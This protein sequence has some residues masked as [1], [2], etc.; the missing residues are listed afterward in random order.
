MCREGQLKQPQA[1]IIADKNFPG[2]SEAFKIKERRGKE[3]AWLRVPFKNV[4]DDTVQDAWERVEGLKGSEDAFNR[5][6]RTLREKE[7]ALKVRQKREAGERQ[8]R[9]TQA[10]A[11]K[12]RARIRREGEGGSINNPLEL[13]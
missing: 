3:E 10:A 9:K 6:K 12:I 11:D 2:D 13:S 7:R 8:R 5:W 4:D 1:V